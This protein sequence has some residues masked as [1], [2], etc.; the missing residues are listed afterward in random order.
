MRPIRVT[1][2]SSAIEG[3]PNGVRFGACRDPRRRAC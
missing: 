1:V 3:F 2:V